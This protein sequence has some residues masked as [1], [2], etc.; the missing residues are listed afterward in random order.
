MLKVAGFARL[1]GITFLG[2]Q[3]IVKTSQTD[4]GPQITHEKIPKI[5]KFLRV[6]KFLNKIPFV[7]SIGV[8]IGIFT[9]IL[10]TASWRLRLLFGAW[11]GFGLWLEF[12][13]QSETTAPLADPNIW[14]IITSNLVPIMPLIMIA[15][16]LWN[17]DPKLKP[18]FK[19]HAGEHMAI[20]TYEADQK[21]TVKNIRQANRV[22]P[23]CGTNLLA[24]YY[25]IIIAYDYTLYRMTNLHYIV[26]AIIIFS[27]AYEIF[28]W[29]LKP[30]VWL[31]SKLQRHVV[32]RE[33]DDYHLTIASLGLEALVSLETTGQ[34]PDNLE[35]TVIKE[36]M[37]SSPN[38][39]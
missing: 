22:H 10:I 2:P 3:Y 29:Q 17:F 8:M 36:M 27:I 14:S 16:I 24:I 21:L 31:G 19:F 38:T 33:P 25:P 7:R 5:A 28:R 18:L 26:G 30:F 39:S 4:N 34:R 1:N 12:R 32:T 11:L 23:R 9:A 6:D 35:Y 37:Q 20:T 15:V 13:P